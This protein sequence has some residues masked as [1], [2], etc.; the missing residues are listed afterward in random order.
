MPASRGAGRPGLVTVGTAVVALALGCARP[1]STASMTPGRSEVPALDEAVPPIAGRVEWPAPDSRARY[2]VQT[3]PGQIVNGATISLID[4]TTGNT[5]ATGLT[6]S[7]GRFTI[8]PNFRPQPDTGY[9]LEAVKGINA[10]TPGWSAFRLRTVLMLSQGRWTSM[11]GPTITISSGTTALSLITVLRGVPASTGITYPTVGPLGNPTS[12]PVM[13]GLN[14]RGKLDPTPLIGAISPVGAGREMSPAAGQALHIDVGGT[15]AVA[16]AQVSGGRLTAV[17]VTQGGTG[18]STPPR[19][20]LTGGGGSGARLG[21]VTV[22]GGAVRAIAVES[23]GSGYTSAPILSVEPSGEFGEVWQLVQGAFAADVDPVATIGIRSAGVWAMSGGLFSGTNPKYEFLTGVAADTGTTAIT[24]IVPTVGINSENPTT[25]FLRG[26]GFGA[27]QGSSTLMLSTQPPAPVP[28]SDILSWADHEIAFRMPASLAAGLYQVTLTV[29]STTVK[30]P[31]FTLQP[32]LGSLSVLSGTAGTTVSV[33]GG[34]GFDTANPA[35]NVL[36]FP[37]GD[38]NLAA[39]TPLTVG[40]GTMTFK[41]PANAISGP[42]KLT[43][44]GLPAGASPLFTVTPAIESQGGFLDPVLGPS[45]Q[46][47]LEGSGFCPVPDCRD[48]GSAVLEVGGVRVSATRWSN[49]EIV[50]DLPG[51]VGALDVSLTVAGGNGRRVT[52]PVYAPWR[53]GGHSSFDHAFKTFY[54]SRNDGAGVQRITATGLDGTF[55][56]YSAATLDGAF[57]TGL[58]GTRAIAVGPDGNIYATSGSTLRQLS[59]TGTVTGQWTFGGTRG[60]G[61]CWSMPVVAGR[62]TPYLF[63]SSSGSGGGVF[64]YRLEVTGPGTTVLAPGVPQTGFAGANTAGALACDNKGNAYVQLDNP[65]ARVIERVPYS[66][67]PAVHFTLPDTA[68]YNGAVSGLAYDGMAFYAIY[69]GRLIRILPGALSDISATTAFAP[70]GGSSN[71]TLHVEGGITTLYY[72]LGATGTALVS[73]EVGGSSRNPA[74][75]GITFGTPYF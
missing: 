58:A 70:G 28:A 62:I 54:L 52:L 2:G 48:Q 18:Y 12:N 4:Q 67:I 25:F 46:V 23:G 27:S 40:R 73:Q 69:G 10:N 43:V 6:D 37:S 22:S 59:P 21:A 38:G 39:T 9:F 3:S 72:G 57:T 14:S 36:S 32:T 55:A 11:T 8:N 68:P 15:G 66:G 31:T 26:R 71:L 13:L 63:V 49:T 7:A 47:K 44:N 42:V 35:R 50:F 34:S 1:F 24:G 51:K 56:S 33:T 65:G 41:I 45:G 5:L 64:P 61:L 19:F 60:N 74:F 17:T 75:T 30:S 53:D 20:T 16:V 29:G